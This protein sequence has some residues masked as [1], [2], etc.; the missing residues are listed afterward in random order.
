MTLF[1]LVWKSLDYSELD[2][3]GRVM[4]QN[5]GDS[6]QRKLMDAILSAT[7]GVQLKDPTTNVN[8][9]T[10]K[11]P[12]LFRAGDISGD[13][14]TPQRTTAKQYS[15]WKKRDIPRDIHRFEM[16]VPFDDPS[17]LEIPTY[18]SYNRPYYQGTFADEGQPLTPRHIDSINRVAE[19]NDLTYEDS[20]KLMDDIWHPAYIGWGGGKDPKPL[21]NAGYDYATWNEYASAHSYPPTWSSALGSIDWGAKNERF[22]IQDDDERAAVLDLL[23]ELSGKVKRQTGMKDTQSPSM[24]GKHINVP[25]WSAWH[26]GDEESRPTHL[27][28][29][30]KGLSRNI[31]NRHH[32]RSDYG[33]AR[34]ALFEAK[35]HL[36]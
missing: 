29:D 3:L 8:L 9:P 24:W 4:N 13:F 18:N 28:F 36:L 15:N 25:Q 32:R 20:A 33:T 16:P 21:R 6:E 11:T 12:T 34:S 2:L 26:F 30:S 14:F 7:I 23:S 22:A 27:G 17:V 19:A 1:D 35:R 5:Q 10:A 31:W